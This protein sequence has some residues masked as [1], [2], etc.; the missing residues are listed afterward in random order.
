MMRLGGGT[1]RPCASPERT[2][3]FPE[4]GESDAA[5]KSREGRASRRRAASRQSEGPRERRRPSGGGPA[6][7]ATSWLEALPVTAL[8]RASKLQRDAVAKRLS[9]RC[10]DGRLHVGLGGDHAG[11]L[12]REACGEDRVRL[13]LADRSNGSA[14]CARAGG[15]SRAR[16]AWCRR[17]ASS[18]ARPGWRANSA[19][20]LV[21]LEHASARAPGC[22]WRKPRGR[23]ARPRCWRRRIAVEQL[24]PLSTSAAAISGS[25][26]AQ[27]STS[28]RSSAVRP[29]GCCS[30]TSFTSF[31][32]SLASWQGA[33]QEDVRVGAAGDRDALALQVLDLRDRRCPCRSPARSIR[34]AE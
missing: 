5:K 17:R 29:S 3:R 1:R 20:L 30:S 23:S 31:S 16:A 10:V 6:F 27:A 9:M 22:P 26:P 34:G 2:A 18:S 11:L 15:R 4:E 33:H 28:P 19:G 21:G 14:R 25:R 8:S 24:A 7:L 13:R 32:V 12:Q